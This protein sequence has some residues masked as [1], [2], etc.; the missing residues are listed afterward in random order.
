VKQWDKNDLRYQFNWYSQTFGLGPTTIL[1]KKFSDRTTTTGAGNDFP[2]YRYAD[3]LL[4]YAECVAQDAAPDADAME[5]LNMVHRRA[6]GKP[7]TVADPAIDFKLSD[8]STK[9]AF[10]DLVVRERAYEDCLEGKHWFDLK[11]LGIAQEVIQDML[12]ITMQ[13]KQLLWPIPTDEYNYN[14]AIDPNTD[15]NPGY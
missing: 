1:N 12:G 4:F 15:Q 6:Y 11:R 3:V 10:I 9:Q 8:Y 13:E 14:K 2:L 5:K 7:S